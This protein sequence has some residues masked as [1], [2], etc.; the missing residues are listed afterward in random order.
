[1]IQIK[2]T[3]L[4]VMLIVVL[5]VMT[6]LIAFLTRSRTTM[7]RIRGSHPD[8][9]PGYRDCVPAEKIVLVYDNQHLREVQKELQILEDILMQFKIRNKLQSQKYNFQ[10]F[11]VIN[12]GNK[13]EMSTFEDNDLDGIRGFVGE[14]SYIIS[15]VRY[16]QAVSLDADFNF[17]PKMFQHSLLIL[18][19]VLCLQYRDILHKSANI[20]IAN[21]VERKDKEYLQQFEAALNE[22][23]FKRESDLLN[24][25]QRNLQ[26]NQSDLRL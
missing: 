21:D 1:M 3:R 11:T 15:V 18:R 2:W 12:I 24:H 17:V 4:M 25:A 7:F 22:L 6:L 14:D 19:H 16:Q 23:D 9:W 10:N 26:L 8:H 13:V 20:Q 5:M